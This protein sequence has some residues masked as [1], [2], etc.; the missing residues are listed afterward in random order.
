MEQHPCRQLS[1]IGE[2]KWYVGELHKLLSIVIKKY[3]KDTQ[4]K[5]DFKEVSLK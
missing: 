2:L 5:E 4:V 1:S 3:D